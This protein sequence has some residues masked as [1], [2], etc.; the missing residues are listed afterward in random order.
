MRGADAEHTRSRCARIAQCARKLTCWSTY[1][2]AATGFRIMKSHTRYVTWTPLIG[3]PRGSP[4]KRLARVALCFLVGLI[5]CGSQSSTT[6][7]ED[8]ADPWRTLFRRPV[9]PPAAADALTATPARIALGAQLFADTRLSGGGQRSCASCHR[10]ELGFT[11]GKPRAEGLSGAALA[12]NTPSLWNLAW[13][14]RFF[15]D[16]RALSL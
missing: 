2:H 8:V 12:R 7:A 5:A 6:G 16:G 10:A 9:A 11:D 3:Q 4:A 1:Q 13:S 14:T 15:W